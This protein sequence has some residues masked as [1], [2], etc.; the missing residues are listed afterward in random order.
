M[1]SIKLLL[2][3]SRVVSLLSPDP[4]SIDVQGLGGTW[5]RGVMPNSERA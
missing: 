1:I 4:A 3:N 2:A 5:A